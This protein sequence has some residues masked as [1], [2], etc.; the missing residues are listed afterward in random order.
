VYVVSLLLVSWCV[1]SGQG[2]ARAVQE[3]PPCATDALTVRAARLLDGR[4]GALSQA[5]VTVRGNTIASIG[6]CTGA[7]THDLGA[8]TILPGLIDVHVHLDWHFGPDGRFGDRPGSPPASDVQRSAALLEN[9]RRTLD[10]GFTTV[11]SLGSPIDLALRDA[12][13]RG[14][15]VGPRILTSAGQLLPGAR[16]ADDLRTAVRLLRANGADVIK[17][18]APDGA[19]GAAERRLQAQLGAICGEAREQELRSIVHAHDPPAIRAAIAGGCG[20]IAHGTFADDESLR[21]IGRAKLYLD[22]HIGL[23]VQN[24]LEHRDAYLGAPGYT[25][26]RFRLMRQILPALAP[27]FRRA[28]DERLRMPLGSDAVAGAHGRNAHELVVRVREGGQRPA[29]AIVSA[30]SLAAESLGLAGSVGTLAPGLQAD[31]VAVT[32]D[33]LR[34]IRMLESVIFVMANGRVH[35]AP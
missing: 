22:P 10:A 35:R 31:A 32:G 27:L 26:E 29:D 19:T 8:A 11:Q 6:P 14:L 3:G 18:I 2:A 4:G 30:T 15:G 33:P 5:V 25:E 9:A 1:Q 28:L 21:A 13:R 7:V 34:D 20:Q 17:A 12:L 23:N 24:Y 16:T